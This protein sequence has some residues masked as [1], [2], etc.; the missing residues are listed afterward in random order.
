MIYSINLQDSTKIDIKEIATWKERIEKRP[1]YP[2]THTVATIEK[3]DKTG[4]S[5]VARVRMLIRSKHGFIQVT[6]YLSLMKYNERWLIVNKTFHG[7]IKQKCNQ[8]R[9]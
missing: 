6:D 2:L 8:H 3:I 5:A 9:N 4:N 1:V 7:N